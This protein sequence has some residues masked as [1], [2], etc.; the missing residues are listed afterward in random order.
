M[1]VKVATFFEC[2]VRYE[3]NV[4]DGSVKKVSEVYIVDALSF[5]E[6]EKRITEEM[7]PYVQGDFDVMAIKRTQYG[8]YLNTDD[9]RFYKAKVV[10][11][12]I[13]EK[14]AKEKKSPYYYIVR[15][16]SIDEA[17]RKVDE[18]LSNTAIDYEIASLDET[19]VLDVFLHDSN[20]D[21]TD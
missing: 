15:A 10:F 16:A 8:E 17:H 11:I 13:D 19:K 2:T 14:T 20:A 7:L 9:E 3:R 21:V 12:T 4:E 1:K 6:T 5:T 18:A